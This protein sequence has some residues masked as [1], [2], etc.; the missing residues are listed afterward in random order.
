MT[1]LLFMYGSAGASVAAVLM[2]TMR[3]GGDATRWIQSHVV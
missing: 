3:A 1:E 2:Q